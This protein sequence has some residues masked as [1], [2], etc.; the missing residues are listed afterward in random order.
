MTETDKQRNVQYTKIVEYYRI[1]RM[2]FQRRREK[3]KKKVR[4][5]SNHAFYTMV[6]VNAGVGT[7]AVFVYVNESNSF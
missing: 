3:K 1:V 5:A 4:C 6:V 7:N 2:Y